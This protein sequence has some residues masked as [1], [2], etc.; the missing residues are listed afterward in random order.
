MRKTLVAKDKIVEYKTELKDL[1]DQIKF[2]YQP[3]L[4]FSDFLIMKIMTMEAENER[5]N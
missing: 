5:S 4:S 1:Y 3:P 2:K